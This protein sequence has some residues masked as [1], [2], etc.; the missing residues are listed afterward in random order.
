M[1][2]KLLTG[3]LIAPVVVPLGISFSNRP[4][5]VTNLKN[6]G[7]EVV[8]QL[9]Y[10]HMSIS[11]DGETFEGQVVTGYDAA[12]K[13]TITSIVIPDTY[14]NEPVISVGDG[15]FEGLNELNHV[16]LGQNIVYIGLRNFSLAPKLTQVTIP[17][18][19]IQIAQFA[20][21]LNNE[22]R[23]VVISHNSKLRIIDDQAF[24][25][26]WNTS[27]KYH[28]KIESIYIPKGVK[29]IGDSAFIYQPNF[30]SIEVDPLNTHYTLINSTNV[31]GSV[32]GKYVMKASTEDKTYDLSNTAVVGGLA[33]GD[34]YVRSL[35]N[36]PITEIVNRAFY[37]C[38]GIRTVD[39][40]NTVTKLGNAAFQ[41]I[42]FATSL[43]FHWENLENLTVPDTSTRGNRLFNNDNFQNI[44]I[45]PDDL[46]YLEPTQASALIEAY[47]AK[48][49]NQSM[50]A[51]A[52]WQIDSSELS[53]NSITI[54][55]PA[56]QVK[57][58][59]ITTLTQTYIDYFNRHPN[60][61]VSF[62]YVV[63][64]EHNEFSF[65]SQLR[66][67]EQ[68]IVTTWNTTQEI[69][70]SNFDFNVTIKMTV[71]N[72]G[73]PFT[74]NIS[75]FTVHVKKNNFIDE[76]TFTFSKDSSYT[77]NRPEE[78]W[79]PRDQLTWHFVIDK[80]Y[81]GGATAFVVER[82]ISRW[83]DFSSDGSVLIFRRAQNN[84][85]TFDNLAIEMVA[86]VAQSESKPDRYNIDLSFVFQP[87]RT[88]TI[89]TET[90][91][92]NLIGSGELTTFQIHNGYDFDPEKS[93]IQSIERWTSI[94]YFQNNTGVLRWNLQT[95]TSPYDY[96]A[97][98]TFDWLVA[99]GYQLSLDTSRF[100]D[101]N[102]VVSNPRLSD[103]K[104]Q[105]LAD[106]TINKPNIQQHNLLATNLKLI[107][108]KNN[109]RREYSIPAASYILTKNDN[110]DTNNDFLYNEQYHVTREE[111]LWAGSTNNKFT[112]SYTIEFKV[113]KAY[114]G[115][116]W[117]DKEYIR[118]HLEDYFLFY[119]ANDVFYQQQA[120]TFKNSRA[121]FNEKTGLSI[122]ANIQ[123]QPQEHS[124]VIVLGIFK[125]INWN[126][127]TAH[128][129]NQRINIKFRSPSGILKDVAN[130]QTFS[131][132]AFKPEVNT[133]NN[134]NN[135]SLSWDGNKNGRIVWNLDK[136][137]T[138]PQ[139]A[140]ND[141]AW[142]QA[143]GYSFS[144]DKNGYSNPYIALSD[145]I[146]LDN[147]GDSFSLPV[148]LIRP[149]NNAT[150]IDVGGLK[151]VVSKDSERLEF[152][153]PTAHI[154]SS[155]NTHVA[156]I[157]S[158]N[159]YS[160]VINNARDGLWIN[161]DNTSVVIDINKAYFG[162]NWNN[163]AFI[164][165]HI[166][167]YLKVTS[168]DERTV[169]SFPSHSQTSIDYF[170]EYLGLMSVTNIIN[171]PSSPNDYR[172]S[173]SFAV[174]NETLKFSTQNIKFFVK[175]NPNQ[176]PLFTVKTIAPNDFDPEANNL[177]S[178]NVILNTNARSADV[179]WNDQ[180]QTRFANLGNTNT[181]KWAASKGYTLETNGFNNE[182]INVS[183]SVTFDPTT[184]ILKTT[185]TQNKAVSEAKTI[186]VSGLKLLIKNGNQKISELSLPDFN[187]TLSAAS[188]EASI[189]NLTYAGSNTTSLRDKG[190][191]ATF[192]LVVPEVL[193]PDNDEQLINKFNFAYKGEGESTWTWVLVPSEGGVYT[194]QYNN[195]ETKEIYTL[196]Y[197]RISN[198]ESD[199]NPRI[200][201]LVTL[202][203][204]FDGKT[205]KD[206]E[207]SFIGASSGGN[208]EINADEWIAPNN[209]IVGPVLGGIFGGIILI[210]LLALLIVLAKRRKEKRK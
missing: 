179:I 73:T 9:T 117:N 104:T 5:Q 39:I 198:L 166:D 61:Q 59:I 41:R 3:L 93:E 111:G 50:N 169:Y 177:S 207:F 119:G 12:N 195:E 109:D 15:L 171:S 130:Y 14:N 89:D 192:N 17:D 83:F 75:T 51:S 107:A 54:T 170:N 146:T 189:Q 187:V 114:F 64:P 157:S 172:I 82:N 137:T 128:F 186:T 210:G 71:N 175:N 206:I 87:I 180:D 62:S 42:E 90:I 178:N 110:L 99:K 125:P 78:L 185:V 36:Q 80:S 13:D 86:D 48:F 98:N 67:N 11:V 76:P 49:A 143:K 173:L 68:R 6:S 120:T 19:C 52:V 122:I 201:Y 40:P 72:G 53:T 30:R 28:G 126:G 139:I 35:T 176:N 133:I 197:Q 188:T 159:T 16:S 158:V 2:F 118:N 56:T 183:T 34:I 121:L 153:L 95:S 142:Y 150:N 155:A 132:D 96:I 156:K 163:P 136:N 23:H 194:F 102:A 60:A 152:A 149:N 92:I 1:K 47:K 124:Y 84:Y 103:D 129:D 193:L 25:G 105:L 112:D 147:N 209:N 123:D 161:G 79:A 63:N 174:P 116:H 113:N 24:S 135:V 168:Q 154:N 22:L 37:G 31:S 32:V 70:D 8:A 100:E 164:A 65:S 141:F 196:T 66:K 55:D 131:A 4:T 203:Q 27:E 144:I 33:Y 134:P 46:S 81:F 202:T 190:D 199:I 145:N 138:D 204:E 57:D 181:C 165:R 20:F 127:L 115:E 101:E 108:S 94:N 44:F 74:L 43:T 140:H 38:W 205:K 97:V 167:Q 10:T 69:F 148:G 18:A 160:D 45:K 26:R 106:I 29:S 7:N 77:Q 184:N 182:Y 162:E 21:Q 85:Y 58:N 191:K 208:I 200:T 88:A 91:Q 151:L